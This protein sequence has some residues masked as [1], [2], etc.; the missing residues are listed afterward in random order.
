MRFID[1]TDISKQIADFKRVVN[2]PNSDYMTGYL[3]ALSV[4]EGMIANA[5]IASTAAVVEVR[6]GEWKDRHENKYANHYYES[7]VCGSP[8]LDRTVSG[9][10]GCPQQEQ[11]LSP[12]CPNCGA[13]MD[14]EYD[15]L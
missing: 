5:M 14:G 15:D 3:C 7:S 6:H 4:T 9:G 2:S 13:K 12:Y 1:A 8:A 10:V 11:V